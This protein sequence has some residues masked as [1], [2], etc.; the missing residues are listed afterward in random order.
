MGPGTRLEGVLPGL[1]ARRLLFMNCQNASISATLSTDSRMTSASL[2]ALKALLAC[3]RASSS[4]KKDFRFSL[5]LVDIAASA[6]HDP[7]DR[8]TLFFDEAYL[9]MLSFSRPTVD[10]T[11]VLSQERQRIGSHSPLSRKD[12][13]AGH[14]EVTAPEDTH[15]PP[16]LAGP[17]AWPTDVCCRRASRGRFF[18]PHHHLSS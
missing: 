6:S 9:S 5:A 8:H 2:L 10:A 3:R 11:V 16:P 17:G 18:S 13:L 1:R 7:F 15:P 4:T 12:S 14:L